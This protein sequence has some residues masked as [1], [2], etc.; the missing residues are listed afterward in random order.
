MSENIIYEGRKLIADS[1]KVLELKQ[2]NSHLK[3][4]LAACKAKCERYEGALRKIAMIPHASPCNPSPPHECFCHL[5]IAEDA[6][7]G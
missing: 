7:N 3:E 6:L 2:E 5:Q 4:E 1:F